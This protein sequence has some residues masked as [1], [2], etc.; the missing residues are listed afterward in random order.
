MI[1]EKGNSEGETGA[2][3][4]HSLIHS[5]MLLLFCIHM[6]IYFFILS[7]KK[8]LKGYLQCANDSLKD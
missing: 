4:A 1:F 3:N 6:F 2:L 8:F 7:F 5:F